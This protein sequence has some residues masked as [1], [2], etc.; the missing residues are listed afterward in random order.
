M[1]HGAFA[2]GPMFHWRRYSRAPLREVADVLAPL[3]AQ[4]DSAHNPC[5]FCLR[6]IPYYLVCRYGFPSRHRACPAYGGA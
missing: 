1:T 5:G 3:G 2:R 4:N 6:F